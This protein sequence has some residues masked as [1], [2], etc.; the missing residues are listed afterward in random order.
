MR[1]GQRQRR[2]RAESRI[3]VVRNTRTPSSTG[4]VQPRGRMRTSAY[5][6]TI[7]QSR[8]RKGSLEKSALTIM[9]DHRSTSSTSGGS[10]RQLPL[11]SHARSRKLSYAICAIDSTKS[12]T[13]SEMMAAREPE[14]SASRLPDQRPR[15]HLHHS[16]AVLHSADDSRRRAR[17]HR[18]VGESVYAVL[19]RRVDPA[20]AKSGTV[21]AA[22]RGSRLRVQIIW[23]RGTVLEHEQR[24]ID[25]IER[26]PRRTS[27]F[28]GSSGLESSPRRRFGLCRVRGAEVKNGRRHYLINQG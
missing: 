1:P 23:G 7:G 6:K 20:S 19:E 11:H 28:G 4:A 13:E 17:C 5:R 24:G 15:A 21:A 12:I 10:G 8:E 14:P 25:S 16:Q 22:C 3:A 2:P 9:S 18:G 26:R 27:A